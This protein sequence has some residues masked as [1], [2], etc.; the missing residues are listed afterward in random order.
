IS[1]TNAHVILE[2]PPADDEDDLLD[3]PACDADGTATGPLP[4]VISARGGAALRAQAER[5]L[6]FLAE[7]PEVPLADI[8]HSLATTRAS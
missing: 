1:G 3:P 4:L 5:M 6:T 8:G 7:R 2:E